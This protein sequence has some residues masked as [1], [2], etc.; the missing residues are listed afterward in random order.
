[1]NYYLLIIPFL[2]FIIAYFAFPKVIAFAKQI[3]YLDESD[4]RKRHKDSIPP[5]GGWLLYAAF[6]ITFFVVFKF[7]IEHLFIFLSFSG[8]FALGVY[9]DKKPLDASI[10]FVFQFLIAGMLVFG[11]NIH[12]ASFI[13]TFGIPIFLGE[14]LCI[15][16]VVFVVNAFNLVD[17]INGL[18]AML[19]I[20]AIAFLSLWLFSAG[21]Y[22]FFI[23][24]LSFIAALIVFLKYNLFQTSVF[25]GDNGS[26]MIG[27]MSVILAYT[28]ID[29]YTGA[30]NQFLTDCDAEVGIALAAMAIPIADTLRLFI[31]RPTFLKKSPFKADRNHVHHLLLRLG[32]THFEASLLLFGLAIL[33]VFAALAA[34]D[35]GSIAVLFITFFILAAFLMSIDF[36]IFSSYRSN[37]DKKT[38]FNR[39]R[40]IRISMNYP[41]FYEIAFAISIFLLAMAIPFHRVS[42][43]IP[44]LILIIS[45][46]VLLIRNF[47][48]YNN[49]YWAV[50][51][52]K[53]KQFVKHPY[54]IILFVFIFY[55]CVH[56]LL[57]KPN[58]YWS[59]LTIYS[60]L[61]VYWICLFQLEKIIPI[62][63]RVLITAYIAGC[64]GF[65]IF[66]LMQ[67]F[68]DVPKMGLSSFLNE[69]LLHHVKANPV[70]H[71]LYYN[72]A[73]VFLGNNYKYLKKEEWRIFY[74]F[75]LFAFILMVI[76]CSSK[77]GW[78]VLLFTVPVAFFYMM[79]KRRF[80]FFSSLTFIAFFYFIAYQFQVIDAGYFQKI[81]SSRFVI[82]HESIQ[83]IK[84]NLW[85]GTGV[86]TSIDELQKAFQAINFER[87]IA[88]KYNV[89]NQFLESFMETGIFGFLILCSFF[90][91]GF[92]QAFKEQNKQ[93]LAYLIIIFTYMIA[94]SLFQTQMGMVAFAF[95]NALFLA[96]FNNKKNLEI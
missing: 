79:K 40:N 10:K 90:I 81:T 77:L 62:K 6:C 76:L 5:I 34:Q 49:R 83:I 15:V 70:T 89:Q 51:N 7:S 69:N 33:V 67:A 55:I 27:L 2:F 31:L 57:I 42:T 44:T 36:F 13:T 43:S 68:V 37:V 95:F 25:L 14:L 26:M 93:Y 19:G 35:L 52:I 64:F 9:D 23:L 73:I 8:I 30:A 18:A 32:L 21:L 28:F 72:L 48:V 80:A 47:L 39:L 1:L 86:G 91:Y 75:T 29:T 46:F 50:I 66:I 22:S 45:F 60:L 38:I 4:G 17:G 58:G 94:E 65:S 92:K 54:S 24:S 41:V 87:G 61:F 12:F 74:W 3:N 20:V 63:P 84:D 96:A 88:E 56:L 16:G 82:W 85:W 78:I 11:G 71:S 53:F 59:K